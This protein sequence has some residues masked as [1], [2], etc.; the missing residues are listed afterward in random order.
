MP[1]DRKYDGYNLMS[2]LSGKTDKSPR[3]QFAYY[4]GLTLEAVQQDEWKLHIPRK[5]VNRVYWA[6]SK[7]DPYRQL[8]RFVLNNL[9]SDK[10]EQNDLVDRNPTKTAELKKIASEFRRE[11]GDWNVRGRDRPQFSY[12]GNVN[13]PN[14]RKDT[15]RKSR[16]RRTKELEKAKS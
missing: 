16:L 14:W 11:L 12:P 15:R 10:R 13:D 4:N 1:D 3:R 6:N 5:Y 7:F 9:A 2:L 8:D